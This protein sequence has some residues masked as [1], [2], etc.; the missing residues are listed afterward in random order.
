MTI[1]Q[2]N[3]VMCITVILF[4]SGILKY[5][6]VDPLSKAINLLRISIEAANLKAEHRNERLIKV[7]ASAASA[8]HRIDN[9]QV[10]K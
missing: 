3:I 6:I 8:H 5:V 4:I 2:S 1:N 7:E 10:K 9:M